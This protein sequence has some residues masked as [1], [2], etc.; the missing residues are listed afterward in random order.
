MKSACSCATSCRPGSPPRRSTRVAPLPSN[1]VARHIRHTY[2][3]MHH[4]AGYGV[5]EYQLAARHAPI[6]VFSRDGEGRPEN[7]YPLD[8]EAYIRACALYRPGPT[9]LIPRGRLRP[10]HLLEFPA[11]TTR[12]LYLA[13]ASESLIPPLLEAA[14]VTPPPAPRGISQDRWD[15]F[16]DGV[17]ELGARLVLPVLT[18]LVPQRLPSIV[19]KEAC[20]RYAPFDLRRSGTLDPSLYYAVQRVDAFLVLHYWFFYAFNDWASGHGGHNDHEGDWESIHLF[21]DSSPPHT[22]RWIAYAAHG[23]ADLERADSADV[24]WFQGHPIVYVGCGSHASYFRPGVYKWRDWAR[25]DA[26]IAIGP[27][28]A[29]AHTWPR[30]SPDARPH[31]WRE[32]RLRPLREM[33][34][35]WHFRGFWGTR[36]RYQW[37]G[38]AFHALH[39]ISGPGGPVWTA[40]QGRMRAQWRN[41]ITWAGFRRHPWEFWKPRAPVAPA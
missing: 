12:S 6:L 9:R 20:Q 18:R 21:L 24:E 14:A 41:P 1:V 32:W 33:R 35:A 30:L 5:D 3:T 11:E 31:I 16:L 38:R 4:R 36:F 34:W 2:I 40:G 26:G 17:Y 22:V 28:G 23:L 13:F 7:F 15:D 37:L 8:A 29:D 25:G 19:W 27:E 39:G 10:E